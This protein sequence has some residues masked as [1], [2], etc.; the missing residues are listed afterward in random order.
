MLEIDGKKHGHG[1]AI[2][3]FLASEFGLMGKTNMD[4]FKIEQLL[5][6]RE[7]MLLSEAKHFLEGDAHKKAEF[8]KTLVEDIYPKFLQHFS[9]ALEENGGKGFVIGPKLSLGDLILYGALTTPLKQHPEIV[10]KFPMLMEHRKRIAVIDGLK[11]H[12]DTL[13]DTPI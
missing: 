7:D 5:N 2:S 1:M 11:Q 10:M 9:N 4:R 12:I 8:D 6:L 13:P 3:T